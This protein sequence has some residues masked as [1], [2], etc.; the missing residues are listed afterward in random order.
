MWD[1]FGRIIGRG[2]YSRPKQIAGTHE[3]RRP[4]LQL[5]LT[6]IEHSGL[7]KRAA[8]VQIQYT[9]GLFV[10]SNPTCGEMRQQKTPDIATSEMGLPNFMQRIVP[11][12]Y[13]MSSGD[14]EMTRNEELP[15]DCT[16]EHFQSNTENMSFEN[17]T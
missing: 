5:M 2:L 13:P 1:E 12:L 15:Q 17:C 16:K 14:V 8:I 9:T 10:N 3:Y 4:Y 6:R 11:H 7:A